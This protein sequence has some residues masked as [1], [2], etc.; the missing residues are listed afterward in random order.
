MDFHARVVLDAPFPE[1]ECMVDQLVDG[2]DRRLGV[3]QRR[4]HSHIG[5][6]GRPDLYSAGGLAEGCEAL[7]LAVGTA[8]GHPEPWSLEVIPTG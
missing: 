2:A 5:R 3:L 4:Y 7:A 1:D 6:T 8:E